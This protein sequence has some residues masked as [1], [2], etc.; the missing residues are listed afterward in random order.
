M[1]KL[2]LTGVSDKPDRLTGFYLLPLPHPNAGPAQMAILG[3]P[4]LP[5]I[6]DDAVAAFPC[7]FEKRESGEH[8]VGFQEGCNPPGSWADRTV[9]P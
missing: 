3:L 1:R 6:D 4:A 7:M 5:V 9:I 8:L 2:S